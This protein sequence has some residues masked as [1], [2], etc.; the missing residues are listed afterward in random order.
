MSIIVWWQR[1][2]DGGNYI[3]DDRSGWLSI[4]V[5]QKQTGEQVKREDVLAGNAVAGVVDTEKRSVD[6]L[7][8]HRPIEI[9][10]PPPMFV[11]GV[12]CTPQ[13]LLSGVLPENLTADYYADWQLLVFPAYTRPTALRTHTGHLSAEFWHGVR[14]LLQEPNRLRQI[15]A[16]E[17]PWLAENE[18]AACGILGRAG[19]WYYVPAVQ[20]QG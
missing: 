20:V 13:E 4:L 11:Y 5:L 8:S 18:A 14:L 15:E 1:W 7:S 16:A 17:D 19:A 10:P 9:Y 12:R 2:S 3:G 6:D